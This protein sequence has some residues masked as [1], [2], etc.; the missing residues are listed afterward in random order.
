[1]LIDKEADPLTAK[2]K[3]DGKDKALLSRLLDPFIKV[4]MPFRHTLGDLGL[5]TKRRH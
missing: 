2:A 5:M 1:L 4:E 3:E